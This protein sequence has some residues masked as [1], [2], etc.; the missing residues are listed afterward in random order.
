MANRL[1]EL[2]LREVSVVDA[3]ANSS[4]DPGTGKK[5]PRARVALF[6]RDSQEGGDPNQNESFTKEELEEFTK[7]IQG[8]T[9]DGVTFPSSDFAY[10]PDPE[11]SNT[12][13]L[14][15]TKTPGGKPDAGI[16]GAAVAALGKGF[17]GN[18]VIIPTSDLASVKAKVRAAWKVANPDK[19]GA[20]LPEVLKGATQNMTLAEMEASVKKNEGIIAGL[21]AKNAASEAERDLVMKMSKKQ[22]KAYASMSPDMQKQ[23]MAGDEEKRKAMCD[24]AMT[25]LKEKALEDSMDAACKA[26]FAKAGPAERITLLARQVE[27]NKVADE[28]GGSNEDMMDKKKKAKA[29]KAALAKGDADAVVKL[30]KSGAKTSDDESDDDDDEDEDNELE[31]KR[32]LAKSEDQ[33]T[34]LGSAVL[35]IQKRQR[36]DHFTKRAEME[37]PNSPGDPIAKGTDLMTMADAM[38]GGETG[39]LFT[40]YMTN[41]KAADQAL[42]GHFAEVGKSGSGP[43]PAEKAFFAK[44]AEIRKSDSKL[45]EAHAVEKV[46]IENPELYI[47]YE[48]AQRTAIASR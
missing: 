27:L 35:E 37:L 30:M 6:K 13:K 22:R 40:K 7:A 16:V 12:W 15:L 17:R 4:V 26:E 48:K 3:P 47:Q 2:E 20:E 43:I 14:R 29:L 23:F 45:D 9:Y 5:V 8:K 34:K 36:I 32:K 18:R 39:E 25:K 46:M 44:V 19:G 41:L 28:E 1:H 38:P 11:K 21:V 31:L 33:V 24:T 42:S 10:V